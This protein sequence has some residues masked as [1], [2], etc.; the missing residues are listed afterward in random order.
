[1]TK[2]CVCLHQ[3]D[4]GPV[5]TSVTQVVDEHHRRSVLSCIHSSDRT[6]TRWWRR[7]ASCRRENRV[8]C[9]KNRIMHITV[10]NSMKHREHES[11]H[12]LQRAAGRVWA[13]EQRAW[14]QGRAV[15]QA[16]KPG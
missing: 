5:L 8:S 10:S 7:T 15:R 3:V 14:R 12:R 6:A 9:H 4:N 1:M 13:V 11:T 16:L 2:Q